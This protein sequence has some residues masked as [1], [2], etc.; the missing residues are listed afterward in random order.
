MGG[1]CGGEMV[2]FVHE[3]E[4]L[5]AFIFLLVY[6]TSRTILMRSNSAMSN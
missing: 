2:S 4:V 5:I 1:E 3:Y 6:G